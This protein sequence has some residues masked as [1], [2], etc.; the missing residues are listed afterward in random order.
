MLRPNGRGEFS[1]QDLLNFLVSGSGD[2]GT[3]DVKPDGAKS[4]LEGAE[5]S[6]G[7]GLRHL[8]AP[9]GPRGSFRRTWTALFPRGMMGW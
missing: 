9:A 1:Q 4:P 7:P 6:S 8:R 5:G 2:G 3:L